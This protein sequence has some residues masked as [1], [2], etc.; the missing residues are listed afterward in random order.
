MERL[1]DL[2][3]TVKA[4]EAIG[5]AKANEVL[6]TIKAADFLKK[7]EQEEKEQQALGPELWKVLLRLAA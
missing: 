6:N 2:I 4:Q 5:V 7:K 1:E 3:K